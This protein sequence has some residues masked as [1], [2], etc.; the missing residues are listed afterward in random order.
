MAQ[1]IERPIR[2]CCGG[3]YAEKWCGKPAT[4]VCTNT[5]KLQWY[6]CDCK[7][8]QR[9]AVQ[10]VTIEEWWEQLDKELGEPYTRELALVILGKPSLPASLECDVIVVEKP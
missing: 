7:E 4:T 5:G 10:T 3:T 8:H 2:R 6:A 9:G 1:T